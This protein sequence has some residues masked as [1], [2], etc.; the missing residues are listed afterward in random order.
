MA[1]AESELA[2]VAA[3]PRG[4][5]LFLD[6][7]GTL[8]HIAD[9]P[10]A[11]AVDDGAVALLAG[12]HAATAGALALITGRALADID[13]LFDPLVL[14][15]AGQ[16]GFERRDARGRLHHHAR[17]GAAFDQ[18]RARC[19]AFG[20]SRPGVLVEDKGLTL[21][22]HFRLAPEAEGEVGALAARIAAES[23]GALAIQRGK[24]VV[25]LKPAGKDKGTAIAEFMAEP[26]FR[27]REPVFV[28]DDLTDEYGFS[29]VNGLGGLSVKVGDGP[30]EAGARLP[31][32]TAVHAWLAR[33]AAAG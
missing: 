10:D 16:H 30:T 18:A 13:R 25:E 2:R 6:V 14:P 3:A 26:P 5:A 29:V 32:V 22:L 28:G 1:H 8:L 33:V 23:G 31:D 11:V 4:V 20:A 27:G 9:R 19:E 17:P 7:D 21:A 15:V 24:M 12:V